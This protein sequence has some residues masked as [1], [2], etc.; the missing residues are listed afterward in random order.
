MG[1]HVVAV[2]NNIDGL[3][4]KGVGTYA[5]GSTWSIDTV[6]EKLINKAKA[7]EKAKDKKG[8]MVH[9]CSFMTPDGSWIDISEAYIPRFNIGKPPVEPKVF[10][11]SK[12]LREEPPEQDE[13]VSDENE[14]ND[15]SES[16][17]NEL[18]VR[19]KKKKKKDE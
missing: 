9:L 15:S 4:I 3:H 5:E 14:I 13:V 16:S 18:S 11:S 2:R 7:G 12:K 19:I 6:P 8:R 10:E 17:S 1:M